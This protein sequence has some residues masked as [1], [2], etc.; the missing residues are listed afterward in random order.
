MHMIDTFQNP[1]FASPFPCKSSQSHAMQNNPRHADMQTNN[2]PTQTDRARYQRKPITHPHKILT[3]TFKTLSVHIA[4]A[5]S[6][7]TICQSSLQVMALAPLVHKVS[8]SYL[9]RQ[10][11]AST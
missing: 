7:L 5:T 3:T 10:L 2:H 6:T 1:L 8:I 4:H 9:G 11:G